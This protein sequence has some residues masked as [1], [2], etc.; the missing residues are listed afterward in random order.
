[1]RNRDD[2]NRAIAEEIN[3]ATGSS[4]FEGDDEEMRRKLKALSDELLRNGADET[5]NEIVKAVNMRP[6]YLAL[7]DDIAR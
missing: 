3:Y 7:A 4:R 5:V 6:H 2:I 1:L